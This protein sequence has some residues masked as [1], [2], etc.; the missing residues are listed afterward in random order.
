M[1]RKEFIGVSLRKLSLCLIQSSQN[2]RDRVVRFP[3]SSGRPPTACAVWMRS[4]Q[5][6]RLRQANGTRGEGFRGS[7]AACARVSR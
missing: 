7:V 6:P 1:S 3:V 5:N 2:P 4:H